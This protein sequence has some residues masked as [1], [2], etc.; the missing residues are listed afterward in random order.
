MTQ[1][2]KPLGMANQNSGG[3]ADKLIHRWRWRLPGSA[4]SSLTFLKKAQS[5]W[6]PKRKAC[7]VLPLQRYLA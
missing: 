4:L 7:K 6:F 1:G 3:R 2:M 5:V